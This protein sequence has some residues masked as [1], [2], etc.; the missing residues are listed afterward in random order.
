L[1]EGDEIK[2]LSAASDIDDGYSSRE[3]K[4][5]QAVIVA[6]SAK[7]EGWVWKVDAKEDANGTDE[8]VLDGAGGTAQGG[9]EIRLVS[10]ST[11]PC[12]RDETDDGSTHESA[13]D[14]AIKPTHVLPVDPMGWH[15]SVM[16]WTTQSLLQDIVLTISPTGVLEFWRPRVGDHVVNNKYTAHDKQDGH[17]DLHAQHSHGAERWMRTGT[18]KTERT[19]I[20]AARCSS[21]KKTVLVRDVEE[22]VESGQTQ[23]HSKVKGRSGGM[24][25]EMTIWDSNVGEFSTGLEMCKMY[26]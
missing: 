23:G 21:R 24:M 11:I 7:G 25:Q 15:Q 2:M 5:Q 18:V 19:D 1:S 22:G 10:H 9:P 13:H 14:N 17:A 3:R 6:V 4:T 20:R 26:P 12:C 8:G 16:D